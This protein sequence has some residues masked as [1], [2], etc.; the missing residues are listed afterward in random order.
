MLWQ[1]T[2]KRVASIKHKL[3]LA[4]STDVAMQLSITYSM[5]V[6][7]TAPVQGQS[8]PQAHAARLKVPIVPTDCQTLTPAGALIAASVDTGKEAPTSVSFE[9]VTNCPVAS[10]TVT[11]CWATPCRFANHN[12]IVDRRKLC[13]DVRVRDC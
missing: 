5:E 6:D 1:S 13:T 11:T 10:S 7:S 3:S 2:H 8:F 12:S 9:Q 4:L